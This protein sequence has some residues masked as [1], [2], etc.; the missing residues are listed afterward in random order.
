M[1][2]RGIKHRQG[3]K[4]FPKYQNTTGMYLPSRLSVLYVVDDFNAFDVTAGFEL[5]PEQ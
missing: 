3:L 1:S 5:P 2:I 4:R